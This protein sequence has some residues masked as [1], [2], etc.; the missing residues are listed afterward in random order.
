MAASI[1]S[2]A[3]PLLEVAADL[4]TVAFRHQVAL[5]KRD[6]AAQQL[7]WRGVVVGAGHVARQSIE[8]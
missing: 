4:L 1:L 3:T 8:G 2:I 5:H 6:D 7:H